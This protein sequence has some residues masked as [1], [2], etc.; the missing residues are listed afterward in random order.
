[1]SDCH[2]VY[3]EYK[4]VDNNWSLPEVDGEQEKIVN[5]KNMYGLL[6]TPFFPRKGGGVIIS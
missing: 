2:Y 4:N 5:Y 1:M 3:S 6:S